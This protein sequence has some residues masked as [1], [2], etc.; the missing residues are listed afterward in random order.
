MATFGDMQIWVSKRLQDPNNTAV[1]SPDVGDL[2]ND[3]I[4]YWKNTRFWFNEITDTTT[5]AQSD[6]S[7]PLPDD[8]L[9]PSIDNCF[10]IEYS[11]IR[12][13]LKKVSEQ[14]YNAMYLS[15]GIGQPWWFAKL[16][17]Q[18]YQVYPIP[19]RD[20]TL[21]RYYLRDYAD[22][23]EPND[24]NDFTDNATRLIQYTAAAYGSRDFRQDADMYSAFWAQAQMEAQSLLETTRKDNAT[25][26]LTI[27]SMLTSY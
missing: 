2:I 18:G 7:V 17:T 10:V 6:P 13:P 12:Y 8:W 25:G 27:T 11:G 21:D 14:Q 1:S 19:D 24:E 3:A 23:V 22:L 26:S 20:Y 9:V 5:L 15:N 4:D 16:A